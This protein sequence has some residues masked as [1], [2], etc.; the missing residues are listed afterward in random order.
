MLVTTGISGFALILCF[1]FFDQYKNQ[2]SEK[3]KWPLM[4][5]GMNPLFTYIFMEF[6]EALFMSNIQVK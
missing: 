3:V 6:L 1:L 2:V 5:F 4:W